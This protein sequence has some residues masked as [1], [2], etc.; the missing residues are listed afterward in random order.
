MKSNENE[1]NKP[2]DFEWKHNN[3]NITEHNSG[4]GI[5]GRR[6]PREISTNALIGVNSSFCR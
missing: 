1:N 3:N 2:N 4:G 5:S 6:F